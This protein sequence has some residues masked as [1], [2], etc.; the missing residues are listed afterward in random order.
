MPIEIL[1]LQ[2]A[3]TAAFDD[4]IKAFTA[5]DESRI[6]ARR[7]PGEWTPVQV[8][9]HIIMATDG[10]P[11]GTTKA[12]DRGIDSYLPLIRPW[13]EDLSKKF[14]SPESLKPNDQPRSRQ[15][16]LAELDRVRKK[17][18]HILEMKDLTMICLDLEL[19]GVGY[20]TRYEWLWFMQMHL[21]RH[22]FQLRNLL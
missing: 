10:V 4:F 15:D 12:L 1:K 14:Q 13:W 11:D 20:L 21:R 5:F 18:L 6:N 22:T 9:S 8:A 2:Q 16:V 17:D 7:V 19:P 3:L